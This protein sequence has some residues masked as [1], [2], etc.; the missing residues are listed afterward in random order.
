MVYPSRDFPK[1]VAVARRNL[2]RDLGALPRRRQ[3]NS[4]A[5]HVE[6]GWTM[7]SMKRAL[8]MIGLVLAAYLIG[9]ALVELFTIDTSNP[10]SYRD[11][12]G[13]PSFFGVLFVHVGPGLVAATLLAV[14]LIRRRRGSRRPS[15]SSGE[16][17][18]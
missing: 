9:R 7:T 10:A 18:R 2:G 8:W 5:G 14:A 16:D 4:A 13:G 15:T 3:L 12:W 17:S 1:Y 6:V 11:D